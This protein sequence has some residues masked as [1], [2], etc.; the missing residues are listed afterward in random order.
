[1]RRRN[2]LFL[3]QRTPHPL[4]L[5][6]AHLSLWQMTHQLWCTDRQWNDFVSYD[7][8][9]PDGLALFIHR[10]ERNEEDIAKMVKEITAFKDELDKLEIKPKQ[11]TDEIKVTWL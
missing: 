7:D 9:L 1:M 2:H 5:Y 8:R 4:F 11:R 10:V 3:T 6:P